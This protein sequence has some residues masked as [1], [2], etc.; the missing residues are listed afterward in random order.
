MC[1]VG[2]VAACAASCDVLVQTMLQQCVADHLRGR[3]MGAWV[4][5][6]GAG[7]VGHLQ[8]GALAGAIG[9]GLT[10]SVNGVVMI[11]LALIAAAA[12]PAVRKCED[13]RAESTSHRAA[14]RHQ[15]PSVL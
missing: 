9:A 11:A 13:S 6:L 10:L 4:L 2:A 5:A 3:A 7:P 15:R 1:A 8:V 12:A 14:R